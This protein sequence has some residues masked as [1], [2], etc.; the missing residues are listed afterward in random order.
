MLKKVFVLL[1]V[2]IL[3]S[4]ST[5][6]IPQSINFQGRLTTSAGNPVTSAKTIVFN[7]YDG[8]GAIIATST[9][10]VT[11]NSNGA[12]SVLLNFGSS[13]FNGDERW[14][15]VVVAGEPLSPRQLITAVPYAYR[16]ITAES[17]IVPSSVRGDILMRD[18]SG[19][20][21][22]AAGTSGQYLKTQGAGANPA[23]SD[24][25]GGGSQW[26]TSGSDIYNSNSGNVGIGTTGPT[27]QLEVKKILTGS[28][29][30]FNSQIIDLNIANATIQTGNLK[31]L[32]INLAVTGSAQFNYATATGLNIDVTGLP[33]AGSSGSTVYGAT[34][35]GGNVGIGTA[36]P[37]AKLHS[38]SAGTTQLKLGY[39][40]SK[41]NDFTVQSNGD[42]Q[43]A[44]N[45]GAATLALTASGR[46]G[47]GTTGP[48]FKLT[49]DKGATTPDGGILAIGT[50]N[51]GATL[52]TAGAG[53]RLIW[54]P[55]KAAFRAGYVNGTQ[56]DDANVGIYSTA[57]GINTSAIGNASVALGGNTTA[58]GGSST[59]MG[60][61]TIASGGCSTAMGAWTT[62]S[63]VQSTAMGFYTTAQPY[64]SLA[65][66]QYNMVS[67]NTSSWVPTEPLFIIGNGTDESHRSNAITVLKNGNVGIGTAEPGANKLKVNGPAEV[68]GNLTVSGQIIGTANN[69]SAVNNIQASVTPAAN[70]LLP[71]DA[72]GK[73]P[74]SVSSLNYGT[75]QPK[76]SLQ[77]YP[78][79]T[80][81]EVTG[82]GH[83]IGVSNSSDSTGSMNAQV[84][85]DGQTIFTGYIPIGGVIVG[86]WGAGS[87]TE[88]QP[89][90]WEYATSL[91][92]TV[93]SGGYYD[94]VF[95]WY[96]QD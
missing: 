55:R 56:W 50:Y 15:E 57:M 44:T 79:G 62:A 3:L 59:A 27:G 10:S 38:L 18:A 58:S 6:A 65:V 48:E 96:T 39:D 46:V 5:F 47:I 24:A 35:M 41:Y 63:G 83:L 52:E 85:I 19:W 16:A 23:W 2:L 34:I 88:A 21:R 31:G 25:A 7:L 49:L 67:G 8:I 94:R 60:S 82:K 32:D 75:L 90:N 71:L 72:S 84:I 61:T 26:T 70:K 54:Y 95:V 77:S 76:A 12:F 30:A 81:L 64:G 4:V 53:T 78:W 28:E 14:L 22:L 43:I 1:G 33:G 74:V 42:L 13:S 29:T 20:T 91:N 86:P 68:T 87:S 11:P 40:A 93:S 51:S 17:L 92:V 89:L 45:G 69:A 73:F 37:G 9:E 66:G 36:S 80:P